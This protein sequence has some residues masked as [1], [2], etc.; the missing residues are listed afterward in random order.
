MVFNKLI[1]GFSREAVT[2]E[3]KLQNSPTLET[4]AARDLSE[5]IMR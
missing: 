3:K 4:L 1:A 2:R 5:S